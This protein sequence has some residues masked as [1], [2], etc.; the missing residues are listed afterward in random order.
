MS[1]TVPHGTGASVPGQSPG[2][3][4]TEEQRRRRHLDETT[5]APRREGEQGSSGSFARAT[6]EVTHAHGEI[7]P[8]TVWEY[9]DSLF[10]LA[11]V[12][13]AQLPVGRY[14][15]LHTEKR[16]M[17]VPASKL[18]TVREGRTQRKRKIRASQRVCSQKATSSTDFLG[19]FRVVRVISQAHPSSMQGK[20]WAQ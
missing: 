6:S 3:G 2:P 19:L 12:E 16:S 15:K 20:I 4:R 5:F 10:M 11:D 9:S 18:R 14:S 13:H 7:E 17:R 8:V 1:L